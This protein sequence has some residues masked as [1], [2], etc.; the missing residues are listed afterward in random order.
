[1]IDATTYEA[2]KRDR[3]THICS[4]AGLRPRTTPEPIQSY[5]NDT[6]ILDLQGGPAILRIAWSGDVTRLARE[7]AV[8]SDLPPEF[9]YP[10]LLDNGATVLD[11]RPLVWML[12]RQ[13]PERPLDEVWP[14]LTIRQRNATVDELAAALR[15]L[16][17]HVPS[18]EAAAAAGHRPTLDLT[19]LDGITGPDVNPFPVPRLTALLPYARAMP[20]VDPGLVDA[21]AALVDE[22]AGLEPSVDDPGTGV[23]VH[24]DVHLGNILATADGRITAVLDLEWVRFGPR[25]LELERLTQQADEDVRG[26]G[27]GTYRPII[28]R[29]VEVYPGIVDVDRLRDRLRLLS[30]GHALRH[31]VVWPPDAPEQS[32][33]PEHPVHR[34]RALVDGSWPA[35]GALPRNLLG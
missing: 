19:T 33:T 5:S 18:A 26:G 23:L 3:L 20:F 4:V 25:W 35:E 28:E 8:T 1:M 11:D 31:L 21:T 29:L 34:L 22:L 30:L 6:W 13:L 9:P 12:T 24:G 7:V 10:N 2:A 14:T 32:L 15:V 16:H 27:G 17:A